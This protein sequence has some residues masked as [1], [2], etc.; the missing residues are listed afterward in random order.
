VHAVGARL[1]T[2]EGEISKRELTE[3]DRE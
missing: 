3:V 2:A 1:L